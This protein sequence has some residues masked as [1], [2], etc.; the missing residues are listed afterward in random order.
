MGRSVCGKEGGRH[1]SSHSFNLR[2]ECV[3]ALQQNHMLLLAPFI[4]LCIFAGRPHRLQFQSGGGNLLHHIIEALSR[5]GPHD[6]CE[7]AQEHRN[8]GF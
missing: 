5:L 2:E 4:K 8:A 3:Q 1:T 7:R 6:G